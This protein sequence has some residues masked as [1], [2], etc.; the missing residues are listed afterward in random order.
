MNKFLVGLSIVAIV[1]LLV[2]HFVLHVPWGWIAVL[3]GCFGTIIFMIILPSRF[4]D[5]RHM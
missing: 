2:V 1:T 4:T 3:F 5:T